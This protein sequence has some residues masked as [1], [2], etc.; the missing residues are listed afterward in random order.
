MNCQ[1]QFFI[2][3]HIFFSQRICLNISYELSA[4]TVYMNCQTQFSAN[5]MY[6]KISL[7]V[8][9]QHANS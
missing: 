9:F 8:H 3:F 2:D 5:Y 6:L 7:A 4:E 1:T